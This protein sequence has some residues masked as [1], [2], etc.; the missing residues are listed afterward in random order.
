MR[1]CTPLQAEVARTEPRQRLTGVL[2]ETT[3]LSGLARK[4]PCYYSA[5][6]EHALLPFPPPFPIVDMV[7]Q[8]SVPTPSCPRPPPLSNVTMGGRGHFPN[9]PNQTSPSYKRS[10]SATLGCSRTCSCSPSPSMYSDPLSNPDEH[11]G[12]D[13]KPQSNRGFMSQA[14]R[15]SNRLILVHAFFEQQ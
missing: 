14:A 1:P 13:S 15:T 6:G 2:N 5:R 8:Y 12:S 11:S 10:A 3:R 4:G 7:F 9:S